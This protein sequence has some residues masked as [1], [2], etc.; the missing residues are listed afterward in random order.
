MRSFHL[1]RRPVG[2]LVGVAGWGGLSAPLLVLRHLVAGY[3]FL[4]FWLCLFASFVV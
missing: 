4:N 2:S 1:S 3:R